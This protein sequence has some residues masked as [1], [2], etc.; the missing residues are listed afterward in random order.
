MPMNPDKKREYDRAYRA[1]NR[2]RIRARQRRWEAENR[3]R[4]N[5]GAR[6]RH[7]PERTAA[8]YATRRD[9]LVERARV[10]R[11]KRVYGLTSEQYW[12]KFADQNGVCAMCGKPET[13]RNRRGT[14]HSLSVDH[15]HKT[16]RVRGLL[17][18]KC[19]KFVGIVE[20]H[21]AAVD[22]YLRRWTP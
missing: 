20:K 18:T 11:L 1:K 5:D 22:A 4:I 15:C 16:G 8:Y 6:K 2:E 14:I 10:D 13:V 7:K 21:G 19:N 9:E 3:E 12:E 17:C